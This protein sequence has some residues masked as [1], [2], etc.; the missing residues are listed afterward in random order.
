MNMQ[1]VTPGMQM[2]PV[3]P[4]VQP[5]FGPQ[6][7]YMQPTQQAPMVVMQNP[8]PQQGMHAAQMVP[9]PQM[10]QVQPQVGAQVMPVTQSQ[11]QM[12]GQMPAGTVVVPQQGLVEVQVF[13]EKGNFL[14]VEKMDASGNTLNRVPAP[15]GASM[16]PQQQMMVVPQMMNQMPQNPMYVQQQGVAYPQVMPVSTSGGGFWKTRT[17]AKY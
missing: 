2:Q 14:G 9:A 6:V 4:G 8:A 5:P 12:Q 11:M 13:D 7:Q 1:P 15:T 17:Q 10:A 3:T 16:M